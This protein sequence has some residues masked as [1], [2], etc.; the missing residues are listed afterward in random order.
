MRQT[1]LLSACFSL[2]LL[3]APSVYA[4]AP[5]SSMKERAFSFTTAKSPELPAKLPILMYHYVEPLPPKANALTI[6]LTVT[7]ATFEEHLKNIQDKGY[8][9][10]TFADLVQ[11][12]STLPEKPIILT[13]DDGYADAYSN[14]FPL[15][16]KYRMKGV[17]YII[18][19][20]VEKPGYMTWEN[21]KQLSGSGMEIG[22]HTVSHFELPKLS[23]NQQTKEIFGSIETI[24]ASLHK[25]V[26]SLAYPVGRYNNDTLKIMKATS[27]PFAVTTHAGVAKKGENPLELLRVRMTEKTVLGKAF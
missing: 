6:G 10:I 20:S 16:E 22:A 23:W 2:I 9:T 8:Q 17:F 14:V 15:L 18:T 3:L 24:Q 26:A 25:K 1:F 21:I 27:V 5:I 19:G 7:P 12:G 13:F 11:S 4:Y